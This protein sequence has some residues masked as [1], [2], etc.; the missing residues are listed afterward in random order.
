MKKY[1]WR[2]NIKEIESLYSKGFSCTE[3][4]KI[5]GASRQAVWGLMKS[6]KIKTRP[7]IRMGDENNFFRGGSPETGNIHNI[8]EY[9]IKKGVIKTKK[10]CENCK[11]VKVFKDGRTGVHAHHPDYNKPLEVIWLCQKCHHAWHKNNKAIPYEIQ[12]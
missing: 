4:G 11:K 7:Q 9:A 1:N 6:H 12:M 10:R 2:L 5:I 3:V 8:L